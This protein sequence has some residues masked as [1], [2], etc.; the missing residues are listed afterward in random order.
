[1][2]CARLAE[3]VTASATA[4]HLHKVR[5]WCQHSAYQARDCLGGCESMVQQEQELCW[6]AAVLLIACI[7]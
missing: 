6:L 4:T 7:V 1:M 5:C 3:A 2:V